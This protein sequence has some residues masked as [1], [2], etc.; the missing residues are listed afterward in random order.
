[1]GQGDNSPSSTP[2]FLQ[3]LPPRCHSQNDTKFPQSPP[4]WVSW[5]WFF[6]LRCYL[7]STWV[8]LKPSLLCRPSQFGCLLRGSEPGGCQVGVCED[9]PALL[10]CLLGKFWGPQLEQ[11]AA[12]SGTRP[13][14][15]LGV[16]SCLKTAQIEGSVKVFSGQW[17]KTFLQESAA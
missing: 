2:P 6:L 17:A 11:G 14:P 10:L 7:F 13:P 12:C 15:A 9:G 16:K 8:M 5:C 3:Q 4:S 1:M